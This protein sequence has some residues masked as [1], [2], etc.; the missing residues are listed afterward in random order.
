MD[1]AHTHTREDIGKHIESRGY[2]YTYLLPYYLELNPIEQF[3][4]VVKNKENV[5]GFV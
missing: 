4:S 2:R 1:N 3:W 5:K